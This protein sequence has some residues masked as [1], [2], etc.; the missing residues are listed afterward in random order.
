MRTHGNLSAP[1]LKAES[2]SGIPAPRIMGDLLINTQHSQS[3]LSASLETASPYSRITSKAKNLSSSPDV[4]KHG[5]QPGEPAAIGKAIVSAT[6]ENLF[7][8][9]ILKFYSFL[10]G[11]TNQAHREK[12]HEPASATS[13]E[14][15]RD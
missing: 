11:A 14:C 13:F 9:T 2:K 6:N 4:H 7:D 5:P 3:S 15:P 8:A 10:P 1:G 12:R